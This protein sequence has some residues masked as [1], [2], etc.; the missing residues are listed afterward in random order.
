MRSW[1]F[2]GKAL[3]NRTRTVRHTHGRQTGLAR[4][5]TCSDLFPLLILSGR[6]PRR[7]ACSH[8]RRVL[9]ANGVMAHIEVDI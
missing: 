6:L 3:R 9:L 4:K 5:H 2:L 7:V 1:N 8:S